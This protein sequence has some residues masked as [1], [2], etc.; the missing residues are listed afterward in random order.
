LHPFA[1]GSSLARERRSMAASLP[2]FK[3][4]VETHGMKADDAAHAP[5]SSPQCSTT[6]SYTSIAQTQLESSLFFAVGPVSVSWQFASRGLSL[7]GRIRPQK[8]AH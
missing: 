8:S 1:F 2:R 7:I 4:V 6:Y 5:L 3:F